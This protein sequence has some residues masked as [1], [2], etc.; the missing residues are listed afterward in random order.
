M[1]CG[2]SSGAG[3]DPSAPS[4]AGD[5]NEIEFEDG[6]DDNGHISH[7]TFARV[8]GTIT[9]S[10][11]G[12]GSVGELTSWD[13]GA[14]ATAQ[15]SGSAPP[16][17]IH[18]IN[19]WMGREGVATT[20]PRAKMI[21]QCAIEFYD[22]NNHN[23]AFSTLYA[24]RE[25][26]K[27]SLFDKYQASSHLDGPD[28]EDWTSRVKHHPT[29]APFSVVSLILS[30]HHILRQQPTFTQS[31]IQPSPSSLFTVP[32]SGRLRKN[33][34]ERPKPKPGLTGLY[35]AQGDLFKAQIILYSTLMYCLCST[36]G[37]GVQYP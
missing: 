20:N 32:R 31:L 28:R 26:D 3:A 25:G 27:Q 21:A 30:L 16:G 34:G 24:N 7:V 1:G 6:P 13:A 11:R 19:D 12:H 8:D 37:S 18:Q 15:G 9:V 14:Y 35:L 36:Q 5:V 33:Q 10:I 22:K 2:A 4:Q 17:K 23:F 29:C